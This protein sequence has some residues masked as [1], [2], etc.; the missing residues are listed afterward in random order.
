M[1]K[2]KQIE[3][4]NGP[5]EKI[6]NRNR[7]D[8]FVQIEMSATGSQR[9]S[10]TELHVEKLRQRQINFFVLFLHAITQLVFLPPGSH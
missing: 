9:S 7:I 4:G 3:T 1:T 8:C 2:I 5:F 10:I 6:R